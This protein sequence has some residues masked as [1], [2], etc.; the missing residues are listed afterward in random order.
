[1]SGP[2]LTACAG[3]TSFLNSVETLTSSRKMLD[4]GS[5]ASLVPQAHAT[6]LSLFAPSFPAKLE[7]SQSLPLS[8]SNPPSHEPA[9]EHALECK[10]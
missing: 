7:D 9:L 10:A 5:V 8:H 6:V 2:V 1:V 3:K 4:T